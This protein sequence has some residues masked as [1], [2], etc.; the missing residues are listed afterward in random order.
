MITISYYTCY[1][2]KDV[3]R[4]SDHG[5]NFSYHSCFQ[6]IRKDCCNTYRIIFG[7]P[8]LELTTTKKK[9]LLLIDEI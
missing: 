5:N 3:F 1:L 7:T 4:I 9:I 6:D 2:G 8:L